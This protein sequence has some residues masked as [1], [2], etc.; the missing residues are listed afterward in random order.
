MNINKDIKRDLI[1]SVFFLFY[2]FLVL[3]VF[4]KLFLLAGGGAEEQAYLTKF[5]F[6][7]APGLIALLIL[8]IIKIVRAF[9]KTDYVDS[10]LHDPQDSVFYN[11]PV[12]R[13][14]LEN[15]LLL[16][17]GSIIFFSSLVYI[18]KVTQTQF[19]GSAEVPVY[20]MQVT[21]I[22]EVGLSVWPPSPSETFEFA[23]AVLLFMFLL[24]FLKH[25]K[26]LNEPLYQ[27]LLYVVVPI[28]S[29]LLWLMYHLFRYGASDLKILNVMW[30][31]Y[32]SAMSI[33]LF[34]TII[35]ALMYHDVNNLFVKLFKMFSSDLV[36][37]ITLI[38]L[39]L[40]TLLFIY[41]TSVSVLR[42]SKKGEP[43]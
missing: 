5:F 12:L 35:P 20:E 3:L 31:G 32:I 27:G 8:V 22:A 6:Y 25:K 30:F 4:P 37:T 26:K 40:L 34:R 11:I 9:V 36:L 18:G 39:I 41:W 10:I 42:K 17:V 14:I 15:P 7:T 2:G 1:T 21:E 28:I 29:T 23:V 16:V 13:T 38:I 33:V 24:K 19:I 43:I